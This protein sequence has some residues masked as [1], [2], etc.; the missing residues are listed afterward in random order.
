[1]NVYDFDNTIYD[2]ESVL[3]FFWFCTRKKPAVLRFLPA[4]LTA[5]V[6]YK[7]QKMSL[8]ALKVQAEKY[9]GVFMKHVQD[10]PA[11]VSEFWDTHQHKIKSFYLENQ[12]QDDVVISASCDFLLTEICHRLGIRHLL[13]SSV[14]LQNGQILEICYRERKPVLFRKAFPGAEIENFYSDSKN[15]LPMMRLAQNAYLVSGNR[16]TKIQAEDK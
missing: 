4:I 2:G 9:L 15:D 5:L 7:L 3:D 16:I 14:D 8:E 10:L 1:M 12:Q 11:L 13:C 6:R